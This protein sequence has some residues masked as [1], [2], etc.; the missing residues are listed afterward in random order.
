M[1]LLIKFYI[2]GDTD[3]CVEAR[4]GQ[5]TEHIFRGCVEIQDAVVGRP[6][7][8]NMFSSNVKAVLLCTVESWTVD[9]GC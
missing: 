3:Q 7:K 6:M 1:S 8:V 2:P 4:L 5:A 9:R